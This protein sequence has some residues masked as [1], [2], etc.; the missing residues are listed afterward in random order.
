MEPFSRLLIPLENNTPNSTQVTVSLLTFSR[1]VSLP[2]KTHHTILTTSLRCTK[3]ANV[4]PQEI[5]DF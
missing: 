4:R 3:I 1:N 2:N 5:I